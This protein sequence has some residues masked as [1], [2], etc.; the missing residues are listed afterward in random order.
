[1]LEQVEHAVL[2]IVG[3]VTEIAGHRT[4]RVQIQHHDPFTGVGSRPASATDVVV[5]PTPPF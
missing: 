2:Q 1:M 5:L 4:M 3:I